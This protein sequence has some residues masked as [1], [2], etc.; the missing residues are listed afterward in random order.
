MKVVVTG[1]HGMIG[2]ATASA[3]EDARHHVV[4]LV[5]SSPKPGEVFWDPAAGILDADDLNG[6]EG[7]VHLAGEGIAA[8]RWSPEQKRLVLDS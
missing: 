1:S 8:K 4:R 7:A 6:V 2:S 3:L 5:R